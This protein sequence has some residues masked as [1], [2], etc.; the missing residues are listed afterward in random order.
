M[1]INAVGPHSRSVVGG[2]GW[3]YNPSSGFE[4]FVRGPVVAWRRQL[5]ESQSGTKLCSTSSTLCTRA[6]DAWCTEEAL[7][8][9]LGL[10]QATCRPQ[11]QHMKPPHFHQEH[12]DE[13]ICEGLLQLAA[14]SEKV[15]LAELQGK[16]DNGQE[17]G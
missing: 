17:G 4:P 11:S 1:M 13:D 5:D 8:A 9:L 2:G 15:H 16:A 6:E 12:G 3:N 14:A 7:S 10:A